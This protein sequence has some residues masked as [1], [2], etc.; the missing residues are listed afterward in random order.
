M[1]DTDVSRVLGVEKRLLRAW[2]NRSLEDGKDYVSPETP[3]DP[4][5][6]LKPG[7]EAALEKYGNPVRMRIFRFCPNAGMVRVLEIGN[8]SRK[9]LMVLPRKARQWYNPRT[10]QV[11]VYGMR[12]FDEGVYLWCPVPKKA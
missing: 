2:R 7:L 8:P 6:W 12:T 5:E 1:N 4:V 10:G 9:G 3:G 11:N